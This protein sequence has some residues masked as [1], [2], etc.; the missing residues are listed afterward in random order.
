MD[1]M[2]VDTNV[3]L[4]TRECHILNESKTSDIE[5]VI[6][7]TPRSDGRLK[8]VD[9]REEERFYKTLQYGIV[10]N[11]LMSELAS[12][13]CLS[14]S[15]FKRRF[16]ERFGTSPHEWIVAKRMEVAYKILCE[17]D[18]TISALAKYCCY[19][20]TSHFIEVFK[21]HYGTTPYTLRKSMIKH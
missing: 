21:N 10:N 2:F 13:C 6:R 4:V 19:N 3:S 12:R 11:V 8:S 20:N 14:L 1:D 18:V 7:L 17:E 15:T 16:R 5:I 9:S